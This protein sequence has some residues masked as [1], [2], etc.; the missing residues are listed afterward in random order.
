ML[1]PL[2]AEAGF[3]RRLSFY[4]NIVCSIYDVPPEVRRNS[5]RSGARVVP[6]TRKGQTRRGRRGCVGKNA[7]N[8]FFFPGGGRDAKTGVVKHFN[9]WRYVDQDRWTGVVQE[10]NG[11]CFMAAIRGGEPLI[12]RRLIFSKKE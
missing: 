7:C 5:R 12:S 4:E 10:R 3:V 2:K 6:T 8:S 9:G 11:V 1:D